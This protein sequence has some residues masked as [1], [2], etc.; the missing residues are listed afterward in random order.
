MALSYVKGE[1]PK[2]KLAEL[3]KKLFLHY[4]DDLIAKKPARW[5][6]PQWDGQITLNHQSQVLLCCGLPDNHE[7]AVLGSVFELSSN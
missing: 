4:V 6:C 3:S 7:A 5:D 1:M 2:E